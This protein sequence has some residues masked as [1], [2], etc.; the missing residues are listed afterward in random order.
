MRR[1]E[2]VCLEPS[3]IDPPPVP[4]MAPYR[5]GPDHLRRLYL[6][7]RRRGPFSPSPSGRSL[8]GARRPFR[9]LHPIRWCWAG[10]AATDPCCRRQCLEPARA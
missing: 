2:L 5:R 3:V 7:P 10:L 4:R 1:R 6:N 9:G 8:P